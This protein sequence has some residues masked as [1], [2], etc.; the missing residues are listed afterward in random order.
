MTALRGGSV[1]CWM[2]DLMA[3]DQSAAGPLWGRYFERLVRLARAKLRAMGRAGGAAVADEEDAALSAFHSFCDG[4]LR[5]RFARWPA[6]VRATPSP[7]LCLA[8]ASF[9]KGA[10]WAASTGESR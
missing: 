1:T 5:G 7:S 2:S 6:P 10:A 3:G 8:I 4:A 9:A